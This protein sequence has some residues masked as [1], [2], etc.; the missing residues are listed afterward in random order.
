MNH[1]AARHHA[2]NADVFAA[3]R[4]QGWTVQRTKGS[5][6]RLVPAD[7]TQP[8]V[9]TG[10]TPGDWQSRRLFLSELRRSGLIWPAP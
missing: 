10:T 6:V 4:R 2:G 7:K 9:V 5:H 3:A 8:M 1:G